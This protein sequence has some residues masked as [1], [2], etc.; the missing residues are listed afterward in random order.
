MVNLNWEVVPKET[1]KIIKRCPRCSHSYFICS[2]KFRVNSNGKSTDVWLIYRCEACDYTWNMDIITRKATREISED[3]FD[4]CQRN[5]MGLAW[6]YAFDKEIISKNKARIHT[7]INLE[8]LGDIQELLNSS[9]NICFIN[10]YSVYFL[11]IPVKK[12]LRAKFAL[13][14]STLE[15]LSD[16]KVI[17]EASTDNT[18]LMTKV[19]KNC[20]IKINLEQFKLSLNLK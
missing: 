9:E 4:K 14:I 12:I 19:G 3:V 20:L 2:E 18:D 7:S 1:P 10:F 16:N 11:D 6:L 15:A 17:T 5:D 8:V 13:S